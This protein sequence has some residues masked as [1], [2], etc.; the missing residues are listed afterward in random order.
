MRDSELNLFNELLNDIDDLAKRINDLEKDH[1]KDLVR[2]TEVR[3]ELEIEID[4][5]KN[6]VSNLQEQ[7]NNR[8]AEKDSIPPPPSVKLIAALVAVLTPLILGLAQIIFG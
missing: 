3:A 6:K 1:G 8:L 7:I 5:L 2:I 4:R